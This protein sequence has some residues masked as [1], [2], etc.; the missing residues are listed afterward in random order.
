MGRH[1]HIREGRKGR[2]DMVWDE[3][4]YQ[5]V[6][7]RLP[8]GMPEPVS[9]SAAASEPTPASAPELPADAPLPADAAPPAD[10]PPP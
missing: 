2:I 5:M 9:S 3:I 8:P 7:R 6:G 1:A 10:A 4:H